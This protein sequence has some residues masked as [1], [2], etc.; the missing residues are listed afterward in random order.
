MATEITIENPNDYYI[1]TPDFTIDDIDD[2]DDFYAVLIVSDNDDPFC[3]NDC[4]RP[5]TNDNFAVYVETHNVT[6]P[7]D[8]LPAHTADRVRALA[9]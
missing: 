1:F 7:L 2:A 6:I 8:E 5:F 4:D 3:A 9:S